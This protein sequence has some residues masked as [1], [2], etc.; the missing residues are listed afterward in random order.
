M[1]GILYYVTCSGCSSNSTNEVFDVRKAKSLAKLASFRAQRA[2]NKLSANLNQIACKL[3]TSASN[4]DSEVVHLQAETLL[5]G[6]AAIAVYAIIRELCCRIY[7]D[8]GTLAL[9]STCPSSLWPVVD[10]LTYYTSKRID[11]QELDELRHQMELKFT[12]RWVSLSTYNE[13]ESVNYRLIEL[14]EYRPSEKEVINL[15]SA[16]SA[17]H[18]LKDHNHVSDSFMP[19]P[20]RATPSFNDQLFCDYE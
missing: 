9:C 6:K 11:I 15:I 7:N 12:I 14:L 1:T 5:K 20:R 13:R 3:A 2:V 16:F 8:M 18:P 10:S 19:T 4:D 17:R